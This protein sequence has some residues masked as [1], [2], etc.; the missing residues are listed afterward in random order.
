MGDFS[1]TLLILAAGQDLTAAHGPVQAARIAAFLY[2]MRN[3]TYAAA[4]FPVGAF[5][6]RMNKQAL[7]AAGYALGAITALL[8]A[9]VSGFAASTIY[10]WAIVFLVAGVYM[11]AQDALEGA[12]PAEPELTSWRRRCF[13]DAGIN[14]DHRPVNP[15][16]QQIETRPGTRVGSRSAD[17]VQIMAGAAIR[18]GS[19]AVSSAFQ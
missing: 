18:P 14:P 5:A 4:F 19:G 7:L 6:D 9:S 8:A 12:I 11:A 2:V 16:P 17:C 3:V 13:A 1:H 15:N 10:L